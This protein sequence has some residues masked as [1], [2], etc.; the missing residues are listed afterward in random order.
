MPKREDIDTWLKRS[1]P[2]CDYCIHSTEEM[3]DK[4]EEG[5]GRLWCTK[6]EKIVMAEEEACQIYEY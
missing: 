5:L 2:M 4:G 6:H 3:P 1:T